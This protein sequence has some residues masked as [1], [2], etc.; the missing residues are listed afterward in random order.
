MI[1]TDLFSFLPQPTATPSP[2]AAPHEEEGTAVTEPAESLRPTYVH[3]RWS[4]GD[5]VRPT[6]GWDPIGPRD[7][8]VPAGEIVQ[9]IPWGLGQLVRVGTEKTWF[10]AGMFA[11]V[12]P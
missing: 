8:I 3:P 9:V 10:P 12:E 2:A 1:A 11:R 5:R 7:V 4:V 6:A